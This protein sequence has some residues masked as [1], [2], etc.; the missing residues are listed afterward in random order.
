MMRHDMN[1]RKVSSINDKSCGQKKEE[2]RE[3]KLVEVSRPSP[4][5]GRTPSLGW[6]KSFRVKLELELKAQQ[7]KARG[8]RKG[9]RQAA[10]DGEGRKG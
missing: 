9:K 1:N 4:D 7:G 3:K 2:S 6:T 5:Q 10:G 8:K